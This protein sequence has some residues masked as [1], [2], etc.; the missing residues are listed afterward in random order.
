MRKVLS[1]VFSLT[2]VFGNAQ[3]KVW[4][5]FKDKPNVDNQILQPEKYLSSQSLERRASQNI[6]N[7]IKNAIEWRKFEAG[8]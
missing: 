6:D 7:Q 8:I 5:F 4:V 2:L 3:E 1:I